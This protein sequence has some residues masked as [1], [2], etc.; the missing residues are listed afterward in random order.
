MFAE[1]FPILEKPDQF[2]RADK[3]AHAILAALS[4]SQKHPHILQRPDAHETSA[5]TLFGETYVDL[6]SHEPERLKL[7]A[8]VAARVQAPDRFKTADVEGVSIKDS[9]TQLRV[10]CEKYFLA[11]KKAAPGSL[12]YKD[13]LLTQTDLSAI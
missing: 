6:I 1:T 5:A 4:F 8:E 12:T 11:I 13:Y 9:Q 3:M 2:A 7:L 10:Q